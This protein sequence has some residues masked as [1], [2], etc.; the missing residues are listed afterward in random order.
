MMTPGDG[1]PGHDTGVGDELGEVD[2]RGIDGS[3]EPP[4]RPLTVVVADDH[5]MWRDAVARDLADAGFVVVG[6]AADGPSA[7][8]RTI[9]ARPDVLVLDLNLPGLRGPEVCRPGFSS[10]P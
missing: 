9:S 1:A 4:L 8:R 7:V 2:P 10:S 6:T 3:C 5:P